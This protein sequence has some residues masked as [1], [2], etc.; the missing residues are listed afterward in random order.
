MAGATGAAG[1]ALSAGVAA[2]GGGVVA[3]TG[4][5][6]LQPESP[7]LVRLKAKASERADRL[8]KR[9]TIRIIE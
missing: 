1:A 3:E 2:A 9:Q 7:R 5:D 4:S 8:E 6:F